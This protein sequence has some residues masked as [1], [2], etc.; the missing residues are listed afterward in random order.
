[1]VPFFQILLEPVFQT[2]LVPS[3]PISMEPV[4]PNLLRACLTAHPKVPVFPTALRLRVCLTVHIIENQRFVFPSAKVLPVQA[5]T[6][7][8][9]VCPI[10]EENKSVI[11]NRNMQYQLVGLNIFTWLK[12]KIYMSK[13][14][15]ENVRKI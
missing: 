11:Y 9:L 10:C 14:R 2:S 3:F 1:M 7:L 6:K 8:V 15:T 12:I 4:F 5:S 13:Y